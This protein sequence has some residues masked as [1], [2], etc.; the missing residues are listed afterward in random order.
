MEFKETLFDRIKETIGYRCK[1]LLEW[2]YPHRKPLIIALLAVLFVLLVFYFAVYRAPSV[3]VS[4]RIFHVERGETLAEVA[5]RLEQEDLVRSAF[6]LR[7]FVAILGGEKNVAAGDYFFSERKTLGEIARALTK[8]DYGIVPARVTIPEGAS[9]IQIADILARHFDQ[10]GVFDIEEFLRL[11]ADKEGYLFPDTY[12]FLASMDAKE[13]LQIL[14]DTFDERVNPLRGEIKAF[15][16][17]FEDVLIMASIIEREART[18]ETRRIIA[19]ILW[20]RLDRE[21]PLQVDVTFDVIN[22][23]NSFELTLDDLDI[24]S[25]FNTY[26]YPGLPPSPI[27]NPGLDAIRATITPIETE[28]Y[29][30]LAD[31]EGVTYYSETFE[32]HK[33]KKARYLK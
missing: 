32:E 25:P 9:V 30:F 17:T 29:Y 4:G 12:F 26:K 27:A 1:G 6:W 31:R 10:F 20:K 21:F 28:Y 2:A 16:R 14:G 5:N 19:G 11:A 7:N 24:D 15:G 23:K 33:E 18:S 22:G 8:A 3:F 13:I